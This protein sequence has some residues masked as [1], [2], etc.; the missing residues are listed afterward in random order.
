[1]GVP[2]R[3]EGTCRRHNWSFLMTV[4]MTIEGGAWNQAWRLRD[5]ANLESTA[6]P[7]F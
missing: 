4:V 2:H 1:M 5:M 7:S 6:G 3:R